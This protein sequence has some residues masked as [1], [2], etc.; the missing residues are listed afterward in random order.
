MCFI[1]FAFLFIIY[2]YSF[3]PN[4]FLPDP[5]PHLPTYSA[6]CFLNQSNTKQTKKAIP[7]KIPKKKKPERTK[8]L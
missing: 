6:S 4:S 7:Q 1:Y 3:P 2:I 5:P 8:T